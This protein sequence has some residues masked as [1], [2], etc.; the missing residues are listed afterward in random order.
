MRLSCLPSDSFHSYARQPL[1]VLLHAV[2]GGH[3]IRCDTYL[4]VDGS[5]LSS[6]LCSRVHQRQEFTGGIP[7]T[8]RHGLVNRQSDDPGQI[9][10]AG[11]RA[12]SG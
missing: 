3:E 1:P 10:L 7:V 4:T 8:N 12:Q 9:A 5:I 6:P 11:S 2:L